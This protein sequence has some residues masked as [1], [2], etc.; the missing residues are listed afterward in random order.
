MSRITGRG[1]EKRLTSARIMKI[2]RKVEPYS[3]KAKP[4]AHP[5]DR[6]APLGF[7]IR[8][9]LGIAKNLKETNF[10]LN[11]RKVEVNGTAETSYK[12]PVGLFDVVG[13]PEIKKKYRMILD[14]QGRLEAEEMEE[15][16]STEK[17]C[18]VVNKRMVTGKKVEITTEDGRTFGLDNEKVNVGDTIKVKFPEQKIVKTIKMEKGKNAYVISGKHAGKT[19]KILDVIPG[20]IQK[21]KLVSLEDGKNTL[22]TVAS[23]IIA[24][25]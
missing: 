25:E 13:V 7:V 4:G 22:E 8:D 2:K 11:A 17:Y 16:E 6:S 24:I 9:M 21:E 14:A 10:L 3:I 15:K 19:V 23:N 5:R 20:T 1:I 18:K 12:L